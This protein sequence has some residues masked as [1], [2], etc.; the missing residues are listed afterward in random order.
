MNRVGPDGVKARAPGR[1]NLIG[2]H[3]DYNDGFVLPMALPFATEIEARQRTDGR[4]RLESVG[5]SSTE[6]GLGDDPAT[7]EPWARYV[8]GMIDLL[9]KD[10]VEISGLDAKITTNIPIGASLSSS[11]ALEV[12][13]GF[14]IC[15]LAGIEPDPVAIALLGQRV[16]NE[17]I[18]IQSG[19]MDQLISAIAQDGFATQIDCRSLSTSTVTIDPSATVLILDT[20]TRRELADS[21]YDLRR[22]ACERAAN[23]LDVP[24]LRDATLD[25]VDALDEGVDKQRARHVVTEN[26]RVQDAVAALG[27]QDLEAFGT[28]MNE[29]HSSLSVDYE[30]S[31]PA[32]DHMSE[33]ARKQDG[34][35]GARMTGGG[36]AGSAVALVEKDAAQAIV[37]TIESEWER[38]YQVRPDIWDVRPS[39]GASV[40]SL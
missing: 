26:T 10:G 32:L 18:G 29:S 15:A 34:C 21:E 40:E 3:T 7:T 16:E 13:S 35:F 6:F 19:I 27:Q 28:L 37:S 11:A 4:I 30:V 24:K 5:Y 25:R 39:A 31:S 20:M 1:V 36:F 9:A 33:L 8:A 17:I 22:V 2:E 23:A 14:A 38:S 12:A